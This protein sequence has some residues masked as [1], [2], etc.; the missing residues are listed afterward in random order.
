M[1]SII[2]QESRRIQE[3]ERLTLI[4]KSHTWNDRVIHF[5][6]GVNVTSS[7]APYSYHTHSVYPVSNLFHVGSPNVHSVFAS[8]TSSGEIQ[9]DLPTKLYVEYLRLYP[10]C[11]SG[12][13][14]YSTVSTMFT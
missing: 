4:G 2:L 5:Y 1:S 3:V 8:A 12:H 7:V 9:F 10:Y 14:R 11:G 6:N 13:N